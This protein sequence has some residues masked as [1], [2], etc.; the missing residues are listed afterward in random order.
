MLRV[1]DFY[2][3]PGGQR[4]CHPEGYMGMDSLWHKAAEKLLKI[5]PTVLA[6]HPGEENALACVMM[7]VSE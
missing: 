5:S 1:L 6:N 7:Q 4:G 2:S 3:L